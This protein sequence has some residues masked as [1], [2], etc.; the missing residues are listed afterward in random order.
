VGEDTVPADYQDPYLRRAELLAR[1]RR[2]DWSRL[3]ET[4]AYLRFPDRD[5]VFSASL[6]RLLGEYAPTHPR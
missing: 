5:E 2:K 6:V 4:L 1:A 3:E